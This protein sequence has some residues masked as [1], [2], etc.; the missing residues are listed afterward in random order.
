MDHTAGTASGGDVD[1]LV[2]QLQSDL[3]NRN[4]LIDYYNRQIRQFMVA[5]FPNNSNTW[6]DQDQTQFVQLSL[7]MDRGEA[8]GREL[9]QL[10]SELR[11]H[12]IDV[13]FFA[14][15]I[16]MGAEDMLQHAAAQQQEWTEADADL[17]IE[18]VARHADSAADPFT[19]ICEDLHHRPRGLLKRKYGELQAQMAKYPMPEPELEPLPD[20][21]GGLMSNLGGDMD[22]GVDDSDDEEVH[23]GGS[24]KGGAGRKGAGGNER[25][26]GVPWTEEEHRQFLLG[27][28][29]FGK[30]DWRSISRNFVITRTPTQVAS[31]AQKYFIRQ[32]SSSR[33]RRRTSIHDIT[34]AKGAAKGKRAAVE[35]AIQSHGMD[36]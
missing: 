6:T 31:H 34:S 20:M 24:L 14:Q 28:D 25:R 17:L 4:D 7:R 18:A 15:C 21:A 5:G 19:L 36:V 10:A 33:E 27:L 13:K 2:A 35:M 29:K 26:K 1:F 12:L 8:T 32:T 16:F 9:Q 23:G 11:R 30:G 22:A 3:R